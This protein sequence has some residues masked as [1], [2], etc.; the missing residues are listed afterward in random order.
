MTEYTRL[1]FQVEMWVTS[2]VVILAEEL[3]AMLGARARHLA[4]HHH[5]RMVYKDIT[6]AR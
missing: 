3:T 2:G 6:L 5:C 1:C 4:V